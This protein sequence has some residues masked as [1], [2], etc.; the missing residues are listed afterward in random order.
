MYCLGVYFYTRGEVVLSRISGFFMLC[1]SVAVFQICIQNRYK[2]NKKYRKILEASHADPDNLEM[3]A[4]LAQ[5]KVR[6]NYCNCT[7]EK[8]MHIATTVDMLWDKHHKY[9]SF[10]NWCL[11]YVPSAL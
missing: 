4:I 10:I 5:A 3:K 8:S 6:T 1:I 9:M 2:L 11:S 7:C